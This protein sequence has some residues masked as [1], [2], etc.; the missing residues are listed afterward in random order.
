VHAVSEIHLKST[1]LFF[2][3]KKNVNRYFLEKRCYNYPGLFKTL[4]S[5][6]KVNQIMESFADGSFQSFDA[7]EATPLDVMQALKSFLLIVPESPVPSSIFYELLDAC[8]GESKEKQ[9]QDVRNLL[10]RVSS[11]CRSLIRAVIDLC[12]KV[13]AS[14]PALQ[15]TEVAKFLGGALARPEQ[16]RRATLLLLFFSSLALLRKGLACGNCTTELRYF[17]RAARVWRGCF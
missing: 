8:Y 4:G 15:I 10:M 5:A 3:F 16:V 7:V 11:S 17:S 2:F 12:R 13:V 14:Q 1:T 9:V 6:P